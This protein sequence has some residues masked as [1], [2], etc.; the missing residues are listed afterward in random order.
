MQANIGYSTGII[1]SMALS[2]T[3]PR[4]DEIFNFPKEDQV[5]DVDRKKAEMI[6]WAENINRENRRRER[7][8]G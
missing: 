6:A 5:P 7:K 8:N 2:K 4:F 1:A 3:R